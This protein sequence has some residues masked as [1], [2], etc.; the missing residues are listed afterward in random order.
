MFKILSIS[1]GGFLGLYAASVL[2]GV[3]EEYGAPLGEYFDLIAG[4]SVGGIIALGLANGSRASEIQEAFVASG[5][6]IFTADPPKTG[7]L[8]AARELLSNALKPKY[9][10]DPLGQIVD[11]IVGHGRTIGDLKRRALIPTVNLTKGAPQV[12]K[13]AHCPQFKRDFKLSVRDVALATSAAPTFFPVHKIGGELFADGG[14]FANSPDLLA[15]HE[16][17]HFLEVPAEDIHVLSVGTTTSR[18]SFSNSGGKNLGIAGWLQDQRL[19]NVMIASNQ[20]IVD[21]MMKHKLGDRYTRVDR[22]QSKEQ[23]RS[24]ALDV[25][26]S[27]AIDDLRALGEASLRDLVGGGAVARFFDAKAPEP[28]FYNGAT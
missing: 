20:A 6:S 7:K 26:S 18:F 22:E 21:F 9:S 4:T 19:P 13:T 23:E 17:E 8:A 15:L 28:K 16:A 27:T 11:E 1:G 3:E 12:F 2:A 25:A 10:A 24:L 5:P 14:M